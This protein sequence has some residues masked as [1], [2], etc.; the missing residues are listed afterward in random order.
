MA[1]RSRVAASE[2]RRPE[3]FCWVFG[4]RKA[5]SA[6]FTLELAV[7]LV[8]V[9]VSAVAGAARRH[10]LAALGIAAV[11]ALVAHQAGYLKRDRLRAAGQEISRVAARS[12]EAFGN[13]TDAYGKGTPGS[14]GNRAVWHANTGRTRRSSPSARAA[15]VTLR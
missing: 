14:A 1:Y 5:R 10:P 2:R 9:P 7:R 3:I 13:A 12:V 15:P 4:G 6:W 11:I 8:A